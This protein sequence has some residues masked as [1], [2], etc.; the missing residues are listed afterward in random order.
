MTRKEER[1]QA[2]LLCF[3]MMFNDDFEEITENAEE[4]RD[5]VISS[6]AKK[7]CM[8]I[9][10]NLEE[11]DR[12]IENNLAKKWKISRISKVSLSILRIAVYE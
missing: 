5:M 11:I 9:K 7:V 10:D 8:G 12:E 3:E 4:T 2:F 1:E 6:F